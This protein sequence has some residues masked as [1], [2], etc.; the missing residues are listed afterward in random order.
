[1]SGRLRL[2]KYSLRIGTVSCLI[3][4]LSGTICVGMGAVA[5]PGAGGGAC[6]WNGAILSLGSRAAP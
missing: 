4:G 3:L 5:P 6:P 1:M 2:G